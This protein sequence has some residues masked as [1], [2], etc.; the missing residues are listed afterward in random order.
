MNMF[1]KMR[2]LL[3]DSFMLFGLYLVLSIHPLWGNEPLQGVFFDPLPSPPANRHWLMDFHQTRKT[4]EKELSELVEATKINFVD[5]HVLIPTTLKR[6]ATPPSDKA[7]EV[8]EWAN[9]Q[10]LDN[11]ADF[12]NLCHRY[13]VQVEIDLANNMW[14]P[15][16]VDT[17]H[18]IGQSGWWPRPDDIPWTESKVWYTQIM[19]YVEARAEHPEA[20]AMWCMFG[21]HQ[22]GGA[23]PVLWDR[24]DPNTATWWA[25]RFVREVWPAFKDAGKRPKAAPIMLPIMADDPTWNVLPPHDRLRAFTHLKHWLVEDLRMPPDFWVM[26]TYPRCDP[27]ED[28]FYYLREILRILGPD[29][30]RHLISTDFKGSGHNID[31]TILSL[32]NMNGAEVLRWHFSKI[33][34]Y[35]LGGWWIWSYRD[36]PSEKTGIR[37][38]SGQWKPEFVKVIRDR[39]ERQAKAFDP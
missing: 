13:G 1:K 17:A 16:S 7:K 2:P 21:N 18:H 38:M 10:T 26:S 8:A 20:I 5:I 27:A 6:K 23:E 9:M 3:R 15:Y 24:N 19:E 35:G 33:D 14:I 31:D 39:C 11:L 4:V 37:T 25:E 30:A 12:V 36:T 34:E 29:A 28:G 32:G 22:W